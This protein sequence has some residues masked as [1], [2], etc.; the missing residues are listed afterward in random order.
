[1]H[2]TQKSWVVSIE[3]GRHSLEELKEE[4]KPSLKFLILPIRLILYL[5]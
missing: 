5:C 3:Y 1:M 4:A 2:I